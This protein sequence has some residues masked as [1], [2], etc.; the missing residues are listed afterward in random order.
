M[1]GIVIETA[2]S[3]FIGLTGQDFEFLENGDGPARYRILNF[4][5]TQPGI[6]QW[7]TVGY[8]KDGQLMNVSYKEIILFTQAVRVFP[9]LIILAIQTPQHI[10]NR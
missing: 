7:D 8:F 10:L 9:A 3:V 4:R 1:R 6:F 5:Q 2:D